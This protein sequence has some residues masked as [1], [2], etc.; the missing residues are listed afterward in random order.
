MEIYTL[1]D[2]CKHLVDEFDAD[3][4]KVD[5]RKAKLRKNREA[6]KRDEEKGVAWRKPKS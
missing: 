2:N 1:C 3:G 4:N 6:K 5:Y